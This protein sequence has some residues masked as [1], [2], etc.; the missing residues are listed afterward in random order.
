MHY[1]VKSR[2][3][4]SK[5]E[6]VNIFDLIHRSRDFRLNNVLDDVPEVEGLCDGKFIGEVSYCHVAKNNG[7]MIQP[8]KAP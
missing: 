2:N 1:K 8:P 6:R 4:Q 7:R 5:Y 3:I